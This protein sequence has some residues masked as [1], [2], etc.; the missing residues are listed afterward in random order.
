MKIRGCDTCPVAIKLAQETYPDGFYQCP[1]LPEYIIIDGKSQPGWLWLV[2]G[3]S[4][5]TM[6]TC[7]YP[8]Q[9]EQESVNV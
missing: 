6:G 8:E 3:G 2:C 9:G 7:K 4:E 1:Y 5:D